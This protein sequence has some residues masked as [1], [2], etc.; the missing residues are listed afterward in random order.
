MIRFMRLNSDDLGPQ[1]LSALK[2]LED[3]I[4]EFYKALGSVCHENF[5]II[6]FDGEYINF[7]SNLQG[8]F[9]NLDDKNSIWGFPK[10]QESLTQIKKQLLDYLKSDTPLK[11]K[12]LE[13]SRK[14]FVLILEY[15]KHITLV[16]KEK[17]ILIPYLLKD[18]EAQ[19]LNDSQLKEKQLLTQNSHVVQ[20]SSHIPC[21]LSLLVFFIIFLLL[22]LCWWFY[23]RPWP[24]EGTLMQRYQ[25]FLGYKKEVQRHKDIIYDIDKLLNYKKDEKTLADKEKSLK[26]QA[27]KVQE[28]ELKRQEELKQELLAQREALLKEKLLLEEQKAQA[29]KEHELLIKKESELKR[30]EELQRKQNLNTQKDEGVKN[31][32]KCQTLR[33]AGKL[34]KL[35]IALDGSFSMLRDDVGTG[36]TRLQAA[37]FA[38]SS[39]VKATDK[40]VDIGLVEINGCPM[41]RNHGFFS[42]SQRNALFSKINNIDPN[43]FFG[44]AEGTSLVHGLNSLSRMVDGVNVDAVGV[45]VSDGEDTCPQTYKMDVCQIAKRIHKRQPKLKIHTVLIGNDAQRAACI[46]KET[47]GRVYSP[48]NAKDITK[49]IVEAGASLKTVC[50]E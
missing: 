25:A 44:A 20:N 24:M 32:P 31:L 2:R 46:A 38:A 4:E 48:K 10:A 33:V 22:G 42:N 26:E 15:L 49:T 7:K 19:A 9:F 14:S 16:D 6:Q 27:L 40:N 39:L 41:S 1:S 23:L 47:G 13:N 18:E 5:P 45:L 29:L 11:N 17:V 28:D 35:V 34:P 43:N 21:I 30:K 12:D 3:W 50:K 36:Q 8:E 37:T